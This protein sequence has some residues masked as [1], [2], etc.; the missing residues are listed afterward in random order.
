MR[1]LRWL[2]VPLLA[3]CGVQP[4]PQAEPSTSD[5]PAVP[6]VDR[7]ATAAA[8]P[9]PSLAAAHHT[10]PIAATR[11]IDRYLVWLYTNSGQG[12]LAEIVVPG[13]ELAAEWHDELP[14][15]LLEGDVVLRSGD[16]ERA[17][18]AVHGPRGRSLITLLR[19]DGRWRV[20]AV[21]A[22]LDEEPIVI[23]DAP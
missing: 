23:V 11:A 3:A 13:T 22:L 21:I 6:A 15:R 20:A 2:A 17:E 8:D 7:G 14:A 1:T 16:G 10:D 12:D 5:P 19:W 9:A 18:V 4:L